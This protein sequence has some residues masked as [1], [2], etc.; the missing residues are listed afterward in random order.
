VTDGYKVLDSVAEVDP[1]LH[2][3]DVRSYIV[4][5]VVFGA[6]SSRAAK[7]R[8]LRKAFPLRGIKDTPPY[9]HD[10]RLLTL[11]DTVEYFNQ[12]LG[13]KLTDQEKKDLVR[14]CVLHS[15]GDIA[16][17]D[18]SERACATCPCPVHRYSSFLADRA[19]RGT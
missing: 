2:M 1:A 3:G 6:T 19:D 7:S 18:R 10:G 8:P 13:T 14:F 12:V 11:D 16:V 9:M 15:V 5:N 4:E 17:H